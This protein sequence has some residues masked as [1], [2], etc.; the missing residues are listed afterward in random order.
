MTKR[1][2]ANAMYIAKSMGRK[3]YANEGSVKD[4]NDPLGG[5]TQDANNPNQWLQFAGKNQEDIPTG[6]PISAESSAV[7]SPMGVDLPQEAKTRFITNA[8][9]VVRRIGDEYIP[10]SDSKREQN[11][12]DWFGESAVKNPDG[13]PKVV[14]HGSGADFSVFRPSSTGEFGPGIYASSLADEATGYAWTHPEETGPNV[15]PIHVRMEQPF[16]AKNP[17]DFWETFGGKTDAEAMQNARKAGYDGVIITRPYTIYDNKRKQ[18]YPTGQDHTHYV[19][20]DPSQIK[21]ATGNSGHFSLRNPDITKSEGGRTGYLDGGMPEVIDLETEVPDSSSSYDS[22][23]DSPANFF[24]QDKELQQSRPEMFQ[25]KTYAPYTGL[26]DEPAPARQPSSR[27]M[28]YAPSDTSSRGAAMDAI[29]GATNSGGT[30]APRPI[31]PGNIPNVPQAK[32]VDPRLFNI[33]NAAGKNLPEGWSWNVTPSGGFRSGDSR[34]HG[35]GMAA[36]IQLVD[37]QG[38][39]LPNYQNAAAF[40][41]YE[42]FAQAARKAQL[43]LHPELN[44]QLRWGGYFSGPV[45][46]YGAKDLM[47]FDLGGNRVPM[48]GGSWE[49][50][51]HERERR[52]LPGAKSVGMGNYAKGGSIAD[53]AIMVM[54]RQAKRQPGRG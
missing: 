7:L 8:A 5:L 41:A 43:D 50:G 13:S 12:Q 35:K 19:V 31:P 20:F 18:F 46:K 2:I 28:A 22:S 1:H 53:R 33:L 37:D 16:V 3:G 27:P 38:R 17:S 40:R 24:R 48:G 10:H 29:S 52:Y 4:P 32:N 14:Y 49:T 51:L 6:V 23:D 15:M 36:D 54:S 47:H 30:D 34:F 26:D 44:D 45:G 11:F 25:Q 42:Q 9:G 39:A 21:S